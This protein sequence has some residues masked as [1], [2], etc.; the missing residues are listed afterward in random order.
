MEQKRRIT[1]ENSRPELA[2]LPKQKKPEGKSVEKRE[3]VGYIE[4]EKERIGRGGFMEKHLLFLDLDGTLLDDSKQVSP[5]NRQALEN[6]LNRGHGVVIATGR[7]LKGAMIQ[8][9]ALG[10]DKSGCFLA[11]Y[12]GG[13]IYDW[14]SGTQLCRRALDMQTVAE[15]FDYVNQRGLHIQTYDREGVL[16]EKRCDN[17]LVRDYCGTGIVQFRVIGD[18]RKDLTEPPVKILM[19]DPDRQVLEQLR[20]ELMEQL[21]SRVDIFFSS[22]TYLEIVAAGVNKGEAVKML[23]KHLDV[24]LKNTVA[25]GDEANDLSMIRTAGLGVAM[26]NATEEVK[27]AAGYVTKNDNNHDGVAEIVDLFLQ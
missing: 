3:L 21:G 18:V 22:S 19:I 25:A 8:A 17:R 10:L 24:P 1:G 20:L 13:V 12:N 14:G 4:T 5:G 6:A 16:V 15:A 23:S 26:A 11:A 2:Y 7:P 27:A 9:Q